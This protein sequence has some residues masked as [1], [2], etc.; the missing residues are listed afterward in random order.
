MGTSDEQ[1][2]MGAWPTHNAL[3]LAHKQWS[4]DLL[5]G[6]LQNML[7]VTEA[8][9]EKTRHQLFQSGIIPLSGIPLFTEKSV[10]EEER[11]NLA[12]SNGE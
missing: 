4:P 1:A 6:I 7:P 2:M 5:S 10:S 9:S 3:V 12:P 8:M 11:R